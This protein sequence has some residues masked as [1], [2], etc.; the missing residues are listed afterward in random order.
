MSWSELPPSPRR[1]EQGGG[2]GGGGGGRP[3][4]PPRMRTY[5]TPS[6]EKA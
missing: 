4:P 6:H 1:L 3:P 5:L 2:G